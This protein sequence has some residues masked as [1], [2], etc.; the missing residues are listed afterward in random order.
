MAVRFKEGTVR[1]REIEIFDQATVEEVEEEMLRASP[2]I[3]LDPFGSDHSFLFS[4][5]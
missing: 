5:E 3:D 4:V 1:S 2:I